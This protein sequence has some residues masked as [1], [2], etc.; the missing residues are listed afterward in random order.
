MCI[1]NRNTFGILKEVEDFLDI[2][3]FNYSSVS[4]NIFTDTV[5]SNSH[6]PKRLNDK[7]LF[8]ISV[9]YHIIIL[10]LKY[11]MIKLLLYYYIIIHNE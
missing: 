5:S 6:P 9:C 8:T 7:V 11:N 1:Y 3:H 10:V 4:K 2:S